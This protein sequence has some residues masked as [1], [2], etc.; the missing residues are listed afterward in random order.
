LCGATYFSDKTKKENIIMGIVHVLIIVSVVAF[1]G[2]FVALGKS[3]NVKIPLIAIIA[4]LLAILIISPIII[5]A[6]E[7]AE[8][9]AEYTIEKTVERIEICPLNTL[10]KEDVDGY[11][12]SVDD[13][14]TKGYKFI[15]E[16][17]YG[18]E[19][20]LISSNAKIYYNAEEAPCYKKVEIKYNNFLF[21]LYLGTQTREI[22]V[23]PETK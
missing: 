20:R 7:K 10:Y 8:A 21:D 17:E 1:I 4:S 15:A 18:F 3:W 22:L 13:A 11:V 16:T 14:K 23:L 19:E 9:N 6:A 2:L 12:I 5:V